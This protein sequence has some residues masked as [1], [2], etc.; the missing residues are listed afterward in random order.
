[1]SVRATLTAVAVAFVA[2]P[3]AACS[4]GVHA[5]T[6][7]LASVSGASPGTNASGA[8]RSLESS[9]KPVVDA[10]YLVSGTE[11]NQVMGQSYPPP[12]TVYDVPGAGACGVKGP[13]KHGDDAVAWWLKPYRIGD[14]GPKHEYANQEFEQN[15][16]TSIR[17]QGGRDIPGLGDG[18]ACAES[19]NS[20]A[21]VAVLKHNIP[22]VVGTEG[23]LYVDADTCGHAV[24]LARIALP[25]L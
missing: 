11:V 6:H 10:C 23:A 18:A 8:A 25:R 5:L 24:A 19:P 2:F 12:A 20:G 15:D 7:P 16:A 13:S 21:T 1:M 4:S 9:D 3:L 14:V 22:D 17:Q